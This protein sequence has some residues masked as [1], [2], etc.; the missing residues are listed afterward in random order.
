MPAIVS[1]EHWQATLRIKEWMAAYRDHEDLISIGAYRPGANATVDASIA[2]RDEV[3]R[4]LQQLVDE[5]ANIAESA[6][7]LSK[8]VAKGVAAKKAPAPAATPTTSRNA[9]R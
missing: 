3:N 8:L 1:T 2:M 4:F 9:A 5:R 7:E 6:V